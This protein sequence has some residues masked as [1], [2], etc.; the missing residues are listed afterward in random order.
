MPGPGSDDPRRRELIRQ[1]ELE[2]ARD[3]A[4]Q[5]DSCESEP[6]PAAPHR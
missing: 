3:L 1:R 6:E 4:A 5:G 2:V